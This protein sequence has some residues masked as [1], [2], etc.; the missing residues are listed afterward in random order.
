MAA[1]KGSSSQRKSYVAQVQA[2]GWIP[3]NHLSHANG[4]SELSVMAELSSG[5]LNFFEEIRLAVV[6]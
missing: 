5:S 2:F 1:N 6:A 4:R 3:S